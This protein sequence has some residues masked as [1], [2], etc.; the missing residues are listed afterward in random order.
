LPL[1]PL[2][3]DWNK[4][5]LRFN[6]WTDRD[7]RRHTMHLNINYEN[8]R[9]YGTSRTGT[10][11]AEVSELELQKVR[12]LLP[13]FKDMLDGFRL[14][15]KLEL[16]DR[17]DWSTFAKGKMRPS[18]RHWA[19]AGGRITL[20]DVTHDMLEN[21]DDALM[22]LLPWRQIGGERTVRDLLDCSLVFPDHTKSVRF[23]FGFSQYP[24]HREYYQ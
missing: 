1:Y 24:R 23:E 19:R 17:E 13:V 6:Y 21:S 9:K 7:P 12:K 2:G 11:I 8:Y 20:I 3:K 18:T 15:L 16:F 14:Q 22:I 5:H 4:Y 10:D